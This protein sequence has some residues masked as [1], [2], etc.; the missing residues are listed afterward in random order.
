M[1]KLLSLIEQ[2]NINR[3]V[4]DDDDEGARK[5]LDDAEGVVLSVHR[6]RP[7]TRLKLDLDLA[8]LA[9]E[10]SGLTGTHT[11]PERDYKARQYHRDYLPRPRRAGRGRERDLGAR[12]QYLAAHPP[13]TAAVRGAA[14]V[15]RDAAHAARRH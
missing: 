7:S 4:E 15:P 9:V 14:S 11:Y 2:M 6:K 5:A 3:A 12:R 10:G 8:P 1:E 13:R